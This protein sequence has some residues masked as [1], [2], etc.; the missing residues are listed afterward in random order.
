MV[1]NWQECKG[2]NSSATKRKR[3]V[4]CVKSFGEGQGIEKIIPDSKC[5]APKPHE[6]EPCAPRKRRCLILRRKRIC[7][8]LKRHELLKNKSGVKELV[9]SKLRRYHLNPEESSLKAKQE[10]PEG[11]ERPEIRKG[12][13]IIDQDDI[14]N[15]EIEIV[16]DG[17]EKGELVKKY[18]KKL[19][20]D[21][22]VLQLKGKEVFELL[23]KLQEKQ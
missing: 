17:N 13:L 7:K 20:K 6:V 23:K 9:H 8:K 22:N 1:S 14:S 18:L 16:L 3:K 12:A 15:K 2:K 4:K 10:E 19:P 5:P 11:F 21:S